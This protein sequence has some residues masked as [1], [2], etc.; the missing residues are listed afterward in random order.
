M[1]KSVTAGKL[2][3]AGTCRLGKELENEVTS[4]HM[5]KLEETTAAKNKKSGKIRK[6]RQEVDVIKLTGLQF[7]DMK[8]PQL[9]SMINYYKRKEDGKTP[10][11]K[12]DLVD[13]L[14]DMHAKGHGSPNSSPVLSDNEDSDDDD[15]KNSDKDSV[16][17][18]LVAI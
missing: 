13:M 16:S 17:I 18:I 2:F 8:V 11:C 10:S 15:Y 5:K 9:K 14:T 1:C 7:K 6:L 12:S 4:R 3:M